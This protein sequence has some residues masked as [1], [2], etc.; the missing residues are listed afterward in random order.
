ML[1]CGETEMLLPGDRIDDLQRAG[2]RI[3][4]NES[5]WRFGMDSVLLADFACPA[6]RDRVIDLG[7]GDGAL[8]LLLWGRE[9]TLTGDGIEIRPDAALRAE[10]SF[11]LNGLAE[12]LHVI[13]GDWTK[14]SLLREGQYTLAVAN[15]PYEEAA[16]SGMLQTEARARLRGGWDALFLS[17]ARALKHGGRFALVYPARETDRVLR[18]MCAAGFALKRTRAVYTR[19]GKDAKLCLSEGVLG[20]RP[21]GV[22]MLPPLA[23][24]TGDGKRELAE[25]YGTERTR[26]T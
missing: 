2:L 14:P 22:R 12:R 13:R 11:A 9:N 10:K 20:A 24:W 8:L 7:C 23:V 4:Q 15:P 1:T 18:W 26:E 17:A 19:P 16:Q 25:I 6:P 5:S 21:G 3:I